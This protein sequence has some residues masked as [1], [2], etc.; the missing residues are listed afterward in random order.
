[1]RKLLPSQIILYEKKRIENDDGWM[2][3]LKKKNQKR[4]GEEAGD[5]KKE[6]K[7]GGRGI[8]NAPC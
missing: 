6:K 5:T 4:R 2:D 8:T 3:F 7:R 1:M